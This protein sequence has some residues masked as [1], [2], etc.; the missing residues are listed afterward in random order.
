MTNDDHNT[1]RDYQKLV[2]NELQR[3]DS[4]VEGLKQTIG[5]AIRH[6]RNNRVQVERSFAAELQRLQ[7]EVHGLKIKAGIWGL[8]G[9]LLPVL[10]ALLLKQL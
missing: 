9:G 3:L 8:V 2:L 6:E 10:T 5:D 1:W 4:S 7:V